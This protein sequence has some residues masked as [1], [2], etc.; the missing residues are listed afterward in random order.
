MRMGRS[1]HGQAE[2][3]VPNADLKAARPFLASKSQ[4]EIL[5]LK[6]SV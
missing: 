2:L 1:L 4:T 5:A 3:A 6:F